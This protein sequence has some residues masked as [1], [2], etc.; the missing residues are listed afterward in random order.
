MARLMG[1]SI[2][3]VQADRVETA[4]LQAQA[5]G[6]VVLLKGAYTV[7]A[8]PDGRTVLE[9]FAN[10]GLATGGTGDVLAGVLVA[11]LAQGLAPFEAAAASAYLHGLAGELAKTRLGMAGMAA[12]D[13]VELISEAWQR[14]ADN[15]QRTRV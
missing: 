7:V 3:E 2:A 14:V 4:R 1:C 10:A 5:W 6:H 13:L 12:G 15:V 8:A 9:P 11:L